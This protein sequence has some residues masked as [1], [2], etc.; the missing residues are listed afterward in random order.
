MTECVFGTWLWV[1]SLTQRRKREKGEEMGEGKR[2]R[3]DNIG[4]R[5][6]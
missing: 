3:R 1:S 6:T 2:R 4:C 5:Q